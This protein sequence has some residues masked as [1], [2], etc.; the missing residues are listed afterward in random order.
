M[1]LKLFILV[2]FFLLALPL[3][4]KADCP[5]APNL[6]AWLQEN[7][8]IAQALQWPFQQNFLQMQ[9]NPNFNIFKKPVYKIPGATPSENPPSS[10]AKPSLSNSTIK[11]LNYLQSY[12]FKP[13]Q[14]WPSSAKEELRNNF[15][16]YWNW[17]CQ[18]QDL[19]KTYE[20]S[21]FQSKPPGF[22]ETFSLLADPDPKP[23]IDP[24]NNLGTTE[25]NYTILSAQDAWNIY[26]KNVAFRLLVEMGKVTP[27]SLNEY[28]K[29][30]I[31]IILSGASMFKKTPQGFELLRAMIPTS[32]LK[33]YSFL[34][35]NK[36][37]GKTRDEIFQKILEWERVN[38][39]HASLP[40][41]IASEIDYK[42]MPGVIYH[43]YQGNPPAIYI[44]QPTQCVY[45]GKTCSDIHYYSLGCSSTA[46]LNAYLFET[47]NI[48]A[49]TKFVE[50]TAHMTWCAMG[51]C[52]THGDDPYALKS[53]SDIMQPI[54]PASIMEILVSEDQYNAWFNKNNP[55]AKDYIGRSTVDMDLKYIPLRLLRNYC[56]DGPDKGHSEGQV[57]QKFSH[58]YSLEELEAQQLWKKMD[59]KLKSIGGCDV[60]PYY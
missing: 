8:N 15:T 55:K 43:G 35:Q 31:E 20:A 29:S 45:K 21:G 46:F 9:P 6:D 5:A 52:A 40:A 3:S 26:V 1:K 34:A 19:Y 54:G 23:L 59:D 30:Q 47:L 49:V 11:S 13:W 39:F 17:M 12:T 25:T 41:E 53:A 44:L 50:P 58:V 4:A 38:L 22:D 14:Y 27:W 16:H 24:P 42:M 36:L 10:T 51:K 7:P 37:L 56:N 2:F 18:A 60:V 48:P 28:N 33:A 57:Y 32:P